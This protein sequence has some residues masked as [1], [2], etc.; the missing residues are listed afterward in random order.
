GSDGSLSSADIRDGSP[1][2]YRRDSREA[3]HAA[4]G[5]NRPTPRRVSR[6]SGMAMG[7]TGNPHSST[8]LAYSAPASGRFLI[9]YSP[10][11]KPRL[12]QTLVVLGKMCTKLDRPIRLGFHVDDEPPLA[13]GRHPRHG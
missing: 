5:A 1:F 12:G 13:I 8:I 2:S 10:L 7:A 6:C 4:S 3:N 11:V 9:T